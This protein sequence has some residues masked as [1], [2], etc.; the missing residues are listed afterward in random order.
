MN[1]M[2]FY[3]HINEMNFYVC[4]DLC[5]IVVANALWIPLPTAF[6]II[7]S[8]VAVSGFMQVVTAGS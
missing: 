2:N 8:Q 7:R 3:V 5:R 1:E 6:D 4:I